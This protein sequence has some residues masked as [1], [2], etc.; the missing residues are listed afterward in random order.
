MEN[1][2]AFG[3]HHLSHSLA[4]VHLLA[5]HE[6]TAYVRNDY[7]TLTLLVWINF[8]NI[9]ITVNVAQLQEGF[10]GVGFYFIILLDKPVFLEEYSFVVVD[11]LV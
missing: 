6:H 1:E 5:V 8:L 11:F 9:K 3:V 10:E 7:A 2:I 4:N